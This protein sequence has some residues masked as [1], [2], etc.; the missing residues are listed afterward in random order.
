MNKKNVIGLIS[1]SALVGAAISFVVSTRLI[2]AVPDATRKP[3]ESSGAVSTNALDC[4]NINMI[5]E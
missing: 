5:R 2:S 4:D 3:L 1:I